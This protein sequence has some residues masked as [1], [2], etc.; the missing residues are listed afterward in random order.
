MTS[1]ARQW[2]SGET[3]RVGDIVQWRP[4]EGGQIVENLT[5]ERV[6]PKRGKARVTGWQ[7]GKSREFTVKLEH[8]L[9]VDRAS[10]GERV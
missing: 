10:E 2:P 6:I 7:G 8:L 1:E 3:A 9:I 4:P 5:V